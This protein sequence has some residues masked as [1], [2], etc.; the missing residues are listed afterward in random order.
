M[1]YRLRLIISIVLLIA[2]TV[3]VGGT[4]LIYAS[5]RTYLKAETE[6]ALDSY[7]SIVN[8]LCLLTSV[9]DHI[10]QEEMGQVLS[11]MTSAEFR[12]WQAVS[13]WQGETLIYR[14]GDE[15]LQNYLLQTEEPN[16]CVYIH[17][18]DA[19]GRGLVIASRIEA[20]NEDLRLLGRYDLSPVYGA[21]KLQ[22]GLYLTVYVAVVFFGIIT[23]VV[24]SYAL[25]M[26]L[27][28]LTGAVRRIS[29]GDLSTRSRINSQDEFG[30]L[31]R[32]FDAMAD[33]LQ[34]NIAQLEGNIERQEN[35]MGAFAHEMKTPMTSIIGFADLLRQG[36]LDENTRM[37][38]AE[39]IYSEGHRLE[40]L[41][42]KM[43]DLLMLKKDSVVM[44]DVW[45]PAFITEI[46][47]AMSPNL[48]NKGIRFVC[49][50]GPGHVQLEPDLMKSL[51]YNLVDN[52]TKAIETDGIIALKAELCP[53]GCRFQ[54]VDNGHGMEKEELGK[55]TD[56]FYRV[57]KVRSR[58]QGGAGLGLALCKQIVELHHGR[59]Q[60]AS[61]PGKGTSVRVT[62]PGKEEQ[63]G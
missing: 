36:N 8:T 43:L 33:K 49:R 52:A 63:H 24:M 13:L 25:T 30:Q 40:R 21:R 55:I 27:R 22:E 48:K 19:S 61:A 12:G 1:S 50:S 15:L 29:K 9:D 14:S 11:Q 26:K 37:M 47:K 23:A 51:L 58:A 56:A 39:Y 57:D 28:R 3:S 32:N 10:D 16:R 34:E 44:K 53:E 59:I 4:V 42:F 20:G 18:D 7:K 45:L 38:A 62:I 46:D 60:F 35:F 6:T 17:V 2:L 54:V 5:F 41:S 31:S